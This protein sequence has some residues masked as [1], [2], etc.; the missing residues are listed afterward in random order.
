LREGG[1]IMVNVG[2]SCVEAE[3]KVRDGSVVMEETLKAMRMVFGEKLFV[4]RLGN[5]GDDSSL[6]LTGDFPDIDLWKNA[7]PSSLRCYVD[8]WKLYSG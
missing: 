6:A 5:R 4:L 3:D 7:L 1:R 8:L 2:G